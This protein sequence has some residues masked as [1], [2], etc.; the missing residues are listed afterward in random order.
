MEIA[1]F[2]KLVLEG[3]EQEAVRVV[4]Q[5]PELAS[6]RR[7]DGVSVICLA[8][9]RRRS[10]LVA[11]LVARRAD[12]DIFE[13]SCTGD[14]ARVSQLVVD[15]PAR[16]DALSPDGF[17]PLGYAAFFGHVEL[18]R[19]LIARGGKVNSAS[20][21]AMQVRPLHSAAAHSDQER[22][23]ELARL[24][25]EAG[26]QPNA[27]QQ[28]GFTALHE[29]AANG[30]LTLIELLLKHGG[31]AEIENDQGLSPAALAREKGR[32]AAAELLEQGAAKT[33]IRFS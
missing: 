6:A 33:Q 30:N 27:K 21:N 11:A 10:A 14:V 2:S 9:Y 20:Q 4:E 32:S 18:L 26:A 25:L 22:A 15:E 5:Q 17:S 31:D 12:L 19:A 13:A 29:A 16:V 24:V 8:V 1:E 3:D 7:A 23:L 28:G